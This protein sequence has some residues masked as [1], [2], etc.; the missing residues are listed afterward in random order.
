MNFKDRVSALF[1]QP[2]SMG[3]A[4]PTFGF[5]MDDDGNPAFAVGGVRVGGFA[6]GTGN[7]A[8]SPRCIHSG[9]TPVKASTD[10]TDSTPVITETYICEVMVPQTT[11]V[12]GIAFF[13][14]SVAS[15]N[16]KGA[17]FDKSGAVLAST[18][19]TAMSGTDAFQRVALS[20]ALQLAP[21]TYYVGL[22]VDNTTA[23]FNTHPVGNFGA[24]KKT[25]ETYGTFTT[26]TP[27]TT[28]TAGQG[29]MATLY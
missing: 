17:I 10:G 25:G 15:G 24:S 27:P 5:Y 28:F 2:Q 20:S 23:R 6:A 1:F 29:P 9:N 3:S 19:S 13:N 16:I 18:A 4:V 21:G 8:M 11:K 14:G 7:R 26:I 12:T 22:Q